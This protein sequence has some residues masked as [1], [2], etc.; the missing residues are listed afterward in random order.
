MP[1]ILILTVSNKILIKFT[2]K[3][4]ENEELL[5]IDYHGHAIPVT[6]ELKTNGKGHRVEKQQFRGAKNKNNALLAKSKDFSMKR[7]IEMYIL[8][9]GNKIKCN[10]WSSDDTVSHCR[11][12]RFSSK[13]STK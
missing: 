12:S 10:D 6:E 4:A 3:A 11:F 8:H 9:V 1:K 7:I 5:G 13:K 2:L